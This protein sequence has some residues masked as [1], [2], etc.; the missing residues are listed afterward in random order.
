[1]FMIVKIVSIIKWCQ[2]WQRVCSGKCNM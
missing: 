2:T 1:M